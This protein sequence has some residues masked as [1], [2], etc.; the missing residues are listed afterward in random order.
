VIPENYL[1]PKCVQAGWSPRLA[2]ASQL[3]CWVLA[4]WVGMCGLSLAAQAQT[5]TAP[6]APTA[7]AAP[8]QTGAAPAPGVLVDPDEDYRLAPGD[9][10][11]LFVEDAPELSQA[12]I[13]LTAAGTFE[14]PFLGIIQAQGKTTL[15]LARSIAASLREQDYLKQP[16]VRVAIKQYSGQIFFIQGAVR[17]P[18]LYQL[19]GR[20][21]LLRLISL[22][23]G[24]LEN[25][26]PTALILRQTKKASP[27]AAPLAAEPAEDVE[28]DDIEIIRV[29]LS[30]LFNQGRTDQNIKLEPGD[31][32]NIP[33]A[34]VFYVAGEVHAPGQFQMKEGTTLR[35]AISLAQGTTFKA[36][37]GRAV[38]Y[39]DDPETS[40]RQEIP[41]DVGAVMNGKKQD[42]PIYPNDIIIIPNSRMK[43]V[44]SVLLNA[45]GTSSARLPMRY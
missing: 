1:S 28:N 3:A 30:P 41:V 10:I 7:P 15:E 25:S 23:G 21:S 11:E 13:R 18:G 29:A 14:M 17:S 20:P 31:I 4:V 24:L 12:Q 27:K 16:Q 22:A 34:K 44:S 42:M 32:I 9:T 38:I 33:P 37:L 40:K 45:L 36:A 2:A 6:G 5:R 19:E 35:Q 39:R 26:G 8:S 43:S